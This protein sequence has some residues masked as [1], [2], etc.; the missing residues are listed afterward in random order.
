MDAFIPQTQ[1]EIN[2]IGNVAQERVT[3]RVVEQILNIPVPQSIGETVEAIHLV[4]KEQILEHIFQGLGVR[5]QQVMEET[6]ET[7]RII[8]QGCA[9]NHTVKRIIEVR[10]PQVQ[11]AT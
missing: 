1:G 9:Q 8:P 10:T 4:S 11:Y 6:T 2:A 3:E 7:V 5:V